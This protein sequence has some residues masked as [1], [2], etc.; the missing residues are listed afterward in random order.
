MGPVSPHW[1]DVELAA[2]DWMW[3]LGFGDAALTKS[4]ADGGVDIRATGAVAQVKAFSIAVGRP[5]VQRLRGAA[6]GVEHA[7]F[8]SWNGYSPNARG[9]ADVAGV[10]LF[11]FDGG[12][13]SIVPSSAAAAALLERRMSGPRHSATNNR[14]PLWSSG[15]NWLRRS[16]RSTARVGARVDPGSRRR[17]EPTP[18]PAGE[19]VGRTMGCVLLAIILLVSAVI[20]GPLWLILGAESRRRA[21]EHLLAWP[22]S[23]QEQYRA[24]AVGAG[25]VGTIVLVAACYQNLVWA[26]NGDRSSDGSYDGWVVV[27]ITAGVATVAAIA[28]V[29]AS[30]HAARV[31][32]PRQLLDDAD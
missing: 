17:F 31:P 7:L 32:L 11:T 27:G 19:V 14:A 26:M 6:H 1:A 10:A 15:W 22:T 16:P 8:F 9:Y 18:S 30:G 4:G 20:G 25:I 13:D 2:L 21:G 3:R 5:D 29:I 12:I 23:K 28:R 24:V